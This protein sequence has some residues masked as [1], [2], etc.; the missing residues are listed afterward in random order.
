[1]SDEKKIVTHGPLLVTHFSPVLYYPV[2]QW[3]L[4][5]GL[6]KYLRNLCS[7]RGR[8]VGFSDIL[9]YKESLYHDLYVVHNKYCK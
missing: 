8:I 6:T 7:V 5:K 4:D 9:I 1:M 2:K 3:V